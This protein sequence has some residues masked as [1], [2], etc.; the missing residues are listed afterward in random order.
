MQRVGEQHADK[1]NVFF[2]QTKNHLAETESQI[3][4]TNTKNKPKNR[5]KRFKKN[6]TRKTS[7]NH[8]IYLPLQDSVLTLCQ[9]QPGPKDKIRGQPRNQEPPPHPTP[10]RDQRMTSPWGIRCLGRKSSTHK[11]DICFSEPSKLKRDSPEGIKKSTVFTFFGKRRENQYETN[12]LVPAVLYPKTC[13]R[14]IILHFAQHVTV[15]SLVVDN[16]PSWIKIKKPPV[17]WQRYVAVT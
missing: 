8:S 16:G 4:S 9:P 15:A 6:Q 7:T 1:K 10:N 11:P 17:L 12:K 3:H 14:R 2:S 13:I 5:L